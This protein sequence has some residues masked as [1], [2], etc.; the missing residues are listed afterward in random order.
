[1]KRSVFLFLA[2]TLPL[3]GEPPD[4]AHKPYLPDPRLTPGVVSD[5]TPADYCTPGFTAKVRHVP[6]SVK[7][8]MF[9]QYHIPKQDWH[10]YVADHLIPLEGGGANDLKNLFPQKKKGPWNQKIKNQVENK[11]HRL[12]CSGQ[13]DPAEYQRD[14]AH[15]W[16]AAHQ[17]YMPMKTRS[18]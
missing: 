3:L 18:R 11:G 8:K 9:E 15:D 14:I 7:R 1:M 12:I 10:L 17:K 4:P 13:V 5:A 2:L 6:A 16:I